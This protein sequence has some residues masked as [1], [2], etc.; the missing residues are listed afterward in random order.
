MQDAGLIDEQPAALQEVLAGN[1]LA[2]HLRRGLAA[3]ALGQE[4]CHRVAG[5]HAARYLVGVGL[6]GR[7]LLVAVGAA[8]VAL[9]E[10]VRY[11]VSGFAQGGAVAEVQGRAE[12]KVRGP[13]LGGLRGLAAELRPQ[14]GEVVVRPERALKP[15]QVWHRR[16]STLD[17]STRAALVQAVGGRRHVTQRGRLPIDRV[18]RRWRPGALAFSGRRR[19][20]RE[21]ALE[22]GELRAVAVH[23]GLCLRSGARRIFGRR[24][25]VLTPAAISTDVAAFVEAGGLLGLDRR[26]ILPL[27]LA[28][29]RLVIVAHVIQA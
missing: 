23:L 18:A 12:G 9:Q 3:A 24:G 11:F 14:T 16:R 7:I 13:Q 21:G 22:V 20:S 25:G 2:L 19:S 1:S 29:L 6:G 17:R 5:L 4:L 10:R 15:R 26:R 27:D 28:P 8:A